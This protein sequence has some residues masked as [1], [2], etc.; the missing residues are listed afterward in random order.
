MTYCS[1]AIKSSHLS[2]KAVRIPRRPNTVLSIN[3][4]VSHLSFSLPS[5]HHH[6]CC[7]IP[8]LFMDTTSDNLMETRPQAQPYFRFMDIPVE[9]RLMIYKRLPRQIKHTKVSTEFGPIIILVTR[10]LPT[11]ILRTSTTVYNEARRIVS[12][13]VRKFVQESQPKVIELQY[14]ANGYSCT[15]VEIALHVLRERSTFLVNH[16]AMSRKKRDILITHRMMTPAT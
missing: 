15:V 11:A 12:D 4:F 10:H 9:L 5:Y 16:C 2:P 7:A 6:A 8:R 13:L 3:Y 14:G 1:C